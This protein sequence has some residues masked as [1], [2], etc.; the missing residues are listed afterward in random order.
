MKYLKIYESYS[1]NK[2][3]NFYAKFWITALSNA[4]NS[5]AEVDKSQKIKPLYGGGDYIFVGYKIPIP[6]IEKISYIII[7]GVQI[8]GVI[9]NPSIIVFDEQNMGMS[10]G[11]LHTTYTFKKLH[12]ENIIEVIEAAKD[13]IK[14]Y[15][16]N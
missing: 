8:N 9:V 6:D 7:E 15:S 13:Y 4:F 3:E 5:I 2:S 16:S 12:N 11:A 10:H 1:S 14:K